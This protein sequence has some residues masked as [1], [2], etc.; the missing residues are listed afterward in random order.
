MLV[1]GVV[2][3]KSLFIIPQQIVAV[4]D[5]SLPVL[6]APVILIPDQCGERLGMCAD[7]RFGVTVVGGGVIGGA[8]VGGGPE[9]E[10]QHLLDND[11]DVQVIAAAALGGGGVGKRHV[12]QGKLILFV[13]VAVLG[14][15]DLTAVVL[16]Q[17]GRIQR[18]KSVAI[19]LIGGD[20]DLLHPRVPN[21]LVKGLIGQQG[22][23]VVD[24]L[25]N[26]RLLLSRNHQH[27]EIRRAVA[28][29][30][31]VSVRC[32]VGNQA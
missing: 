6:D 29:S 24:Q 7:G 4:V 25:G 18:C 32:V 15:P 13:V 8:H 27:R 22:D 5:Y 3:H 19:P 14:D 26:H 31:V 21:G 23:V 17:A 12:Q 30:P 9:P 11:G 20:A 28:G 16:R 1:G 10:F 2:K